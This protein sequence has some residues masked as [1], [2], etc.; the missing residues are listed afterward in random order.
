MKI[1]GKYFETYVIIKDYIYRYS[2]LKM[3]SYVKVDMRTPQ[4]WIS[5]GE[6]TVVST[7]KF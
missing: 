2:L 7:S 1:I 4:A 6:L 5:F 3:F